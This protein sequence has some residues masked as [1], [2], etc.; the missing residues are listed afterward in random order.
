M[1]EQQ[2]TLRHSEQESKRERE[3]SHLEV[4]SMYTTVGFER[5]SPSRESQECWSRASGSL[6]TKVTFFVL[7]IVFTTR[8]T[9][10]SKLFLKRFIYYVFTD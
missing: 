5:K 2:Q 9:Y 8:I 10:Q 4:K 3:R 7:C 6:F 1:L